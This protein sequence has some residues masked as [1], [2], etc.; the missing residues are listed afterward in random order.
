MK[1]TI[2]I[3]SSKLLVESSI[4]VGDADYEKKLR[5]RVVDLQ[6]AKN[7]AITAKQ[8]AEA[9]GQPDIAK[10]LEDKI[11]ELDDLLATYNAD[12]IEDEDT[13][14]KVSATSNGNDKG[15]GMDSRP[16]PKTSKAGPE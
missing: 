7:M 15:S 14:G 11:S 16:A 9:N 12:T 4:K 13:A 5:K 6:R 8:K 3:K 1:K 2:N 10:K